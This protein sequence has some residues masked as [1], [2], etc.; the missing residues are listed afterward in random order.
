LVKQHTTDYT[1]QF[2][3]SSLQDSLQDSSTRKDVNSEMQLYFL[4]TKSFTQ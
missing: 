2:K 1:R 3:C 4:L